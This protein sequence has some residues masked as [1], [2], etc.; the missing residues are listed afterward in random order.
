MGH[1]LIHRLVEIL[2]GGSGGGTKNPVASAGNTAGNKIEDT[3]SPIGKPLGKGLETIGKP[4]G[5]IVDP[6]VGG[7]MRS[8]AGFGDAVGVGHGNMDKRNEEKRQTR[9]ELKEP[10]GG[11]EQNADNP[12]GL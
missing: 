3:L 6:L 8:G 12:L 2:G 1:E 7:V 9:E 10:I 5:G 11:K 4:V